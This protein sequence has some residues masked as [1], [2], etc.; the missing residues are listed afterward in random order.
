[1][2]SVRRIIIFFWPLLFWAQPLFAEVCDKERPDW[3]PL[4]SPQTA[5]S[6]L[7]M[8]LTGPIGIFISLM[9]IANLCLNTRWFSIFMLGLS[10]LLTFSIMVE[11]SNHITLAAIRE[12]CMASPVLFILFLIAICDAN[13]WKVIFHKPYKPKET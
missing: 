9:T 1:M 2:G 4:D 7:V 3:S 8:F 12:G 5:I 10:L 6:E 13:L 11:S